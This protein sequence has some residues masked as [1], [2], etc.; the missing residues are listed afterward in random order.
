MLAP[1]NLPRWTAV[2]VLT[3][4]AAR[5]GVRPAL[6]NDA[7]AGALAEW[8]W[9]AA[10]GARHVVFLTMG[11]APRPHRHP[12]LPVTTPACRSR[13]SPSD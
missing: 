1:P 8:A 13:A 5:F 6:L 2:D 10:R 7:D 9:G 12:R 11:T 3:P 4:F